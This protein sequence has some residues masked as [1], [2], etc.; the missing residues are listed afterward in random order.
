[1]KV[2]SLQVEPPEQEEQSTDELIDRSIAGDQRA[3][4]DLVERYQRKIFRV[5]HA[6]LREEMESDLVTQDAFVQAWLNLARFERR[7]NFETWLTRIAINRARDVIRSRRW[8]VPLAS[9]TDD[10]EAGFEPVDDKADPE[11]NAVSSQM[12]EAIERAVNSL[13]TQQKMIF[14]LRHY[15]NLSM[16]EISQ[17]MGLR[18]GTVRAHLFRAV[19]KLRAEL[20]GWLPG[21]KLEGKTG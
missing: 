20:S 9:Q 1:M 15:E 17:A 21:G 16:D 6:I 18:A 4:A 10:G 5:A 7:S 8:T 2:A 11:R 3:F 12:N 13:S 19:H 14:R